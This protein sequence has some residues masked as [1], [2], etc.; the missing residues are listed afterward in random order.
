MR[1]FSVCSFY[2]STEPVTVSVFAHNLIGYV[3]TYE[4]TLVVCGSDILKIV[5]I[6]VFGDG[7]FVY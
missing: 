5:T 2:I 1:C 4:K 3:V 6:L 7:Y